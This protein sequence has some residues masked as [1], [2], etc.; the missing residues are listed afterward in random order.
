MHFAQLLSRTYNFETPFAL[1]QHQLL[2]E[3]KFF[4]RLQNELNT[5]LPPYDDRIA[6]RR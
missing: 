1:G 4:R 2:R 3:S 6:G 5:G